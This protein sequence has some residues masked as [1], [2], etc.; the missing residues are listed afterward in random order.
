MKLESLLNASLVT[1]RKHYKAMMKN[2]M[3]SKYATMIRLKTVLF[4]TDNS[5]INVKMDSTL[6]V[7]NV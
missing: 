2:L 3:S 5:A 6:M 4:K 1:K 7:M